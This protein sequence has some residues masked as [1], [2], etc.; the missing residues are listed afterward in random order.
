[1]GV[2]SAL[3][4]IYENVRGEKKVH[5]K[6]DYSENPDYKF[7]GKKQDDFHKVANTPKV[8]KESTSKKKSENSR[9]ER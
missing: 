5:K 7:S 8:T 2:I 1:M 3:L 9:G 6:R 4:D